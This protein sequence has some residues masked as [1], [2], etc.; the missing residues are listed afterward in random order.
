M[1]PKSWVAAGAVLAVF[2]VMLFSPAI[3]NDGD[4]WWHVKAGEWMLDHRIVP[5]RDPFAGESPPRPWVPHEWL[6]EILLAL[7]FRAAGWAGVALLTA[8]AGA[9][10]LGLLADRLARDLDPIALTVALALVFL[11]WSGGLLA[12]PHVLAL[13]VVVAWTTGLLAARERGEAPSWWLIPLLV[14]WANLHGG[15]AFGIALAGF[16]ALEALVETGSGRIVTVFRDWLLF[17]LGCVAAALLTPHGIDGLL[18]P[19]QLLAMSSL[20]QIGEWQP[21][22][23]TGLVPIEIVLL[24]VIA[25]LL[26]LPVR[27]SATRIVLLLLLLHLALHQSRHGM[28]LAVVGGLLLAPAIGQAAGRATSVKRP[29]WPRQA[30]LAVAL[31][32]LA[33]SRLAW[34]PV[35]GND[36]TAPVAALAAVPRDVRATPVLNAYAFGGYLIWSGI[37]P[38]IDS[39]ADMYGDEGM[40][41][42]A[43]LISPDANYLEATLARDRIGWTIFAPGEPLVRVLD[44]MPG[45]RRLHADEVAVVHIRDRPLAPK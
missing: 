7:S 37:P 1:T 8:F 4:T 6:A 9:L 18:F 21:V 39:R 3:F 20:S 5:H 41:A 42:Y 10:A 44:A 27:L 31:L 36:P 34:P 33:G 22:T 32:A 25:T 45:W 43:R 12:R 24:V 28:L 19:F 17:G 26:R 23:F 13:P 30:I 11:L 2:A 16:F 35:R 29:A 14:V 40:F 15:F 38:W